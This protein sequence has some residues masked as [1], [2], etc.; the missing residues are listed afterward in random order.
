MPAYK[1]RRTGTRTTAGKVNA[2]RVAPRRSVKSKR[3]PKE[4]TTKKRLSLFGVSKKLNFLSFASQ[5]PI[6]TVVPF[7]YSQ[8]IHDPLVI[9]GSAY[10]SFRLNG[11]SEIITTLGAAAASPAWTFEAPYN[12]N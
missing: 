9:N 2:H 8:L 6:E 11:I 12:L 4:T 5:T 10:H 7:C 1:P 3:K